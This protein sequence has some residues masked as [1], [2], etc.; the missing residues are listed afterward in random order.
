MSDSEAGSLAN[1]WADHTDRKDHQE[2]NLPKIQLW[3]LP[4]YVPQLNHLS[5]SAHPMGARLGPGRRPWAAALGQRV[6]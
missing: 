6:I 2:R 1:S 5:R 4:N 3:R